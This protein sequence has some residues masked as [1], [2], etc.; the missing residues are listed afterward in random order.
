MLRLEVNKLHFLDS[1]DFFKK[2]EMAT[3]I[4]SEKKL[5]TRTIDLNPLTGEG[6]W[7]S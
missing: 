5:K 6:I 2:I 1:S 3:K 7:G 4:P